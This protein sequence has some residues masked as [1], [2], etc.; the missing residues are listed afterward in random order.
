MG[1]E[2]EGPWGHQARWPC[3]VFRLPWGWGFRICGPKES[4]ADSSRVQGQPSV[5]QTRWPPC[6]A[7]GAPG[8]N[9]TWSCHPPHSPRSARPSFLQTAN[10]SGR[11]YG[12][13]P[14]EP[15]QARAARWASCRKEGE[16]GAGPLSP[17][18][19]IPPSLC[20][21]GQSSGLGQGAAAN[22]Q[23]AP[24]WAYLVVQWLGVHF[25]MQGTWVRSLVW[26]D[27]TSGRSTKP[28]CHHNWA[29]A[30]EPG[31]CSY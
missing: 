26:E 8:R 17:G 13:F 11:E 27:P 20:R 6:E 5:E 18:P 2:R 15:H 19:S 12:P 16:V 7:L 23:K 29:C 21:A 3:M 4:R 30:P 10:L 22:H 28:M 14:R 31:H 9:S 25:A 24:L 1:V